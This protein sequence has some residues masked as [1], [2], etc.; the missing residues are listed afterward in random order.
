M[1][2]VTFRTVMRGYDPSEVERTVGQLQQ[3]ADQARAEAADRTV[4][5]TK[6][7]G[8]V[9]V[10]EGQ[11][12]EHAT[13]LDALQD[14]RAQAAAPS[15]EDLGARVGKILSLADA[16]AKELVAKAKAEADALT[17]ET[18]AAAE[19]A[20]SSAESYA[21]EVR[22]KADAEATRLVESAK[23]ESD[24]IL[25][26]ADREATAR[27]EEAEAIFEHQRAR[28]AQ[29]AAD[30][31]QT[32]ADRRDKAAVEFA[33][34]MT[35]NEAAI[36]RAEERQAA[37]EAEA[38]RTR[39]EAQAQAQAI[40]KAAQD[41]AAATVA[42]A[43]TQA[44]KV[45]RESDRELQAATSRRDAI[46]A[47]LSNVRQMLATLTGTSIGNDP[48]AAFNAPEEPAAPAVVA[49]APEADEVE[50]VEASEDVVDDSERVG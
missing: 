21:A 5:L 2:D 19:Q 26:H 44:E 25:D 11:L 22:S 30:F 37:I 6:L 7:R 20:R 8:H 46:T 40:V 33:E 31:E 38:D 39:A 12:A 23:R 28:A 24:D 48:L 9:A 18:Q 17:Q 47:Q 50:P 42:A 1:S 41:E 10:L 32:L 34:Q 45:R 36:A 3:A 35:A 16:E 49:E 43:R 13:Q 14:E 4:E 27:R 15:F 29:A